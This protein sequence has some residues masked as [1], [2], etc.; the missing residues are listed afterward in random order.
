M[1]Y[2]F[3]NWGLEYWRIPDM[4]C[5]FFPFMV[6]CHISLG[7]TSGAPSSFNYYCMLPNNTISAFSFMVLW[8]W[9]AALLMV[10]LINAIYRIIYLLFPRIARF[11]KSASPLANTLNLLLQIFSW[12]CDFQV[13][14]CGQIWISRNILHTHY[15]KKS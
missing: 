2:K 10:S 8:F 3:T 5:S 15:F 4:D 9:Y 6:N 11:N 13:H 12:R 14:I 1:N 7:G